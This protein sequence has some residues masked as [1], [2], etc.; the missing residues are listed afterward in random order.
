MPMKKCLIL[1]LLVSGSPLWG[2]DTGRHYLKLKDDSDLFLGEG[3][4][5]LKEF[6]DDGLKALE[7]ARERARAAL[8]A[9]IQVRITSETSEVSKNG[10]DGSTEELSSKSRSLSDLVLENIRSEDFVDFPEKGRITVLAYVTKE[11][12]R[13]QLAGKAV[14]VYRPE[15][16]LKLAVWGLSLGSFSTIEDSSTTN[17]APTDGFPITNGNGGNGGGGGGSS[18]QSGSGMTAGFGLE[19]VWRDFSFGVDEYRKDEPLYVFDPKTKTYS[20]SS[21]GLGL[22]MASATWQYIPWN[23]R[24]QPF[25]PVG[26][27]IGQS[28]WNMYMAGGAAVSAGAGLRYWPSDAFSFEVAFRYLQGFWG[29]PYLKDGEPLR[30]RSNQN[31]EF[32]LTGSQT[33]VAIQWSGF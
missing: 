10:K 18:G 22:W 14:K 8:A 27:H 5:E 15:Y 7:A 11:D 28:S 3:V 20:Q 26:L 33:R 17:G 13:R 6:K 25:F 21:D 9:S 1:A 30:L 19:F 23:T 31:A 29:N 2:A 16:G 32:N 24:V 12:Y 4:A